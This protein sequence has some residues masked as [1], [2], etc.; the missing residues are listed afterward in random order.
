MS[1]RASAR[2][3][4]PELVLSGRLVLSDGVIPGSVRIAGGRITHVDQGLSHLPAAVDL[5][6]DLLMPGLI[7]LHTD[8]LERHF[9]PRSG[10]QWDAVQAAISHDA[11]VI[12]SGITTVYDS[13]TIGAAE[14]WDMRAD[15]VLPMLEGLEEAVAH[16]MLRADH[17]LHLRAEITHEQIVEIF[18]HHAERPLVRFMSLMD[19]AP[20]DRQS[21]DIE[22]Y[23]RRYLKIFDGDEAVLD[24]HVERLLHGS[25]VL[26][27]DHRRRLA[28]A[29]RARGIPFA[30]HDDASE[31]HVEEA[32][33]LGAVLSEFPTTPEAARAARARG[34]HVLM[35]SP[36]LIRGGSHAGN[37][38]AADLAR[39]GTLDILSSDYIPG[40]LLLAVFR[41][42]G[43][44]LGLALPD[45][46]R[47]VTA[48]P[49][50]AAGLGDRGRI[51]PGLRADLIRVRTINGRPIVRAAWR[52]GERVA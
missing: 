6:D 3:A 31:A 46:V 27:P 15:Y 23:R 36:N 20:G 48:N 52:T 38:A 50:D 17:L 32:A 28:A 49:A 5:G 14:G 37:V 35:G 29:A 40:S 34:L 39:A 21:P 22:D 42:A 43:D 33:A 24:R 10:V 2:L 51:E 47:A 19:H 13:I 41:L 1:V 45:A 9:Q 4:E 12:G 44:E 26:G 8:N 18:A 7:D 16:G 25:R 30:S 11:Q